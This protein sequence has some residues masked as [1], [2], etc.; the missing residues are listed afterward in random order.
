MPTRINN[1]TKEQECGSSNET[2]Q[3]IRSYV[4]ALWGTNNIG[5]ARGMN[6]FCGMNNI[7]DTR[8]VNNT[9]DMIGDTSVLMDID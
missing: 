1:Y 2:D 5:D 4:D 6:N 3:N 7:G 8:G 9:P